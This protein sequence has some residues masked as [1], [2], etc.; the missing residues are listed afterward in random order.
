M[1]R[2]RAFSAYTSNSRYSSSPDVNEHDAVLMGALDPM[3]WTRDLWL[4]GFGQGLWG[5]C[6]GEAAAKSRP[7]Q[8]ISRF[9]AGRP[10]VRA[11]TSPPHCADSGE[12]ETDA[13]P[14]H[15]HPGDLDRQGRHHRP[16]QS[17]PA[18]GEPS[19]SKPSTKVRR[20]PSD[21]SHTTWRTQGNYRQQR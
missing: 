15:E 3:W 6:G 20:R 12:L 9:A 13:R 11:V 16:D 10:R 5:A 19:E 18:T 2:H 4:R 8:L 7:A 17:Y 14:R 1:A 21:M